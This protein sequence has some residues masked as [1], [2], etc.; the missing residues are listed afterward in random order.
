MTKL[1]IVYGAPAS[2]KSTYVKDRLKTNDI[3]YDFDDIMQVLTGLPYQ[4]SNK[5]LV[6][7]VTS[8]RDMII[9]RLTHETNIDTAY[10]ITTFLDKRLETNTESLLPDYVIMKTDLETCIK[11]I[12]DSN[13]SNKSELK[14]ITFDWFKR[15]GGNHHI[16]R[17]TTNSFHKQ[18]KWIRKREVILRR[19]QYMCRHCKRYGKTT[20][21][22][23]VHHIYPVE[24][25]P[26]LGLVNENLISLCNKCH[27][28]MHNRIAGELTK[29][30]KGWQARIKIS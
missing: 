19:D 8:V 9:E 5:N 6:P 18:P 11:R 30:G 28:K 4:E 27:E 25:Y 29:V 3:V 26:H 10:I 24:D 7:Y 23:M 22:E 16:K 12:N 20:Q 1:V 15:Y 21:A 14:N 13:R 17:K 2:G